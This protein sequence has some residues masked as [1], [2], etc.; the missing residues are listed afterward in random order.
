MS[1][2]RKWLRKSIRLAASQLPCGTFQKNRGFCPCCR[3]S[4]T[5]FATN[6]WFRDN[7][8]CTHCKSTPRERA[9][10]AALDKH[11]PDWP[12]LRIH[13]SSPSAS[14][15][16][17]AMRSR[18]PGYVA[19]QFHPDLPLGATLDGHSN[20]NL[21]QQT[22]SDESFDLVVT[23]DVM[24]HLYHPDRAFQEIARTLRKGGAHVFSVPVI[25]RHRK[26]EVWAEPDESGQLRFLST[27]EYHSNPID[28]LGCPVTMHW[29]FDIV[30]RIRQSCGME[31]DIEDEYDMERG[32]SARYL[33]IFVSRKT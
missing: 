24:E 21:E 20:Q 30:D 29:G 28:P 25:N 14:G 13:E 26:S 32:L 19:S 31:T 6:S 7:Y 2:L 9:L 3:R 10:I 11:F 22:F 17:L 8:A 23:Q 27:P 12:K 5:F 15:A 18:C 4:T 1:L 33:E 16:S